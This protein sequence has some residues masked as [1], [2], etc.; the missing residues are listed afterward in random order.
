MADKVTKA[1][2]PDEINI[3]KRISNLEQR[4]FGG[5]RVLM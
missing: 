4:G 1:H 5:R 3:S 2:L